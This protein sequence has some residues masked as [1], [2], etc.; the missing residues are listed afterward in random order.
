MANQTK[1]LVEFEHNLAQIKLGMFDLTEGRL[2]PLLLSPNVVHK[3]IKDVQG[4]L[5]RHFS[6]FLVTNDNANY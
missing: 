3:M 2:S 6:G 1:S 4:I 5:N